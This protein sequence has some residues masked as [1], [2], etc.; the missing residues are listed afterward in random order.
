MPTCSKSQNFTISI[1]LSMAKTSLIIFVIYVSVLCYQSRIKSANQIKI[2]RVTQIP[3]KWPNISF[4]F[5]IF[6]NT[7]DTDYENVEKGKIYIVNLA[8]VD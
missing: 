5:D 1:L 8:F 7:E 3:T 2:P 6:E 4:Y